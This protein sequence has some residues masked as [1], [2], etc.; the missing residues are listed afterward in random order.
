MWR[1]LVGGGREAEERLDRG[2]SEVGGKGGE[3]WEYWRYD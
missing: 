3:V 1:E 2:L